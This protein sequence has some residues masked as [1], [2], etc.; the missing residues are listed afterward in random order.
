MFDKDGIKKYLGGN[1]G[2]SYAAGLT[3]VERKY[4]PVDIDAEFE[5]DECAS[6]LSILEKSKF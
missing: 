5:K 3:N 6:L 4:S 1:S 2:N